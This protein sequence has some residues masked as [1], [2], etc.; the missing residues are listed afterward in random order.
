MVTASPMEPRSTV[1]EEA[2]P[3]PSLAKWDVGKLD[4]LPK[5]T[6][7]NSVPETGNQMF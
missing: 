1:P 5:D 7:E 6:Q 3:H 2:I 4:D